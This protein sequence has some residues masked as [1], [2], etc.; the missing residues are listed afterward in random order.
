MNKALKKK[1]VNALRSGEYKQGRV[2]LYN[3]GY[4]SF[5]CLGVLCDVAGIDRDDIRGLGMPTREQAKVIGMPYAG[6]HDDY[7]A[8]KS[9]IGRLAKFN[10][11]G[12]SFKWIASYIERYL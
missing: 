7:E 11:D 10:D 9:I 1:W 2:A 3:K 12:K 8:R 4:D 6:P 5:C